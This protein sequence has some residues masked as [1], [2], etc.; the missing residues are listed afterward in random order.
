MKALTKI[1]QEVLP[2]FQSPVGVNQLWVAVK[3][4]VNIWYLIDLDVPIMVYNRPPFW[5]TNHSSDTILHGLRRSLNSIPTFAARYFSTPVSFI[6]TIKTGAMLLIWPDI[7][8]IMNWSSHIKFDHFKVMMSKGQVP[9]SPPHPL[10]NSEG[11]HN[12]ILY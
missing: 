1:W 3:L 12:R 11:K 10:K 2:E 8:N 5:R 9:P 4:K 7:L 6:I